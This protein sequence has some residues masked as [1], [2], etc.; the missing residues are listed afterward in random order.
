MALTKGFEGCQGCFLK[1][2]EPKY[3][4]V[5]L[6]QERFPLCVLGATKDLQSPSQQAHLTPHFKVVIPKGGG[7]LGGE[8]EEEKP[9][10]IKRRNN[11]CESGPWSCKER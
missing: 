4:H 8:R 9:V 11:G 7:V 5:E 10:K 2:K 6:R 1:F 3:L